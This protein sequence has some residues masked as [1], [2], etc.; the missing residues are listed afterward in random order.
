MSGESDAV[1]RGVRRPGVLRGVMAGLGGAVPS[2][3]VRAA[4]GWASGGGGPA[5]PDRP[6]EAGALCEP[7]RTA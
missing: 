2:S 6:A 4:G 5:A 3:P 1:V 7:G